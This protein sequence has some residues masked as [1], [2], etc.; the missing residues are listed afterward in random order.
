MTVWPV[1]VVVEDTAVGEEDHG[2]IPGPFNLV[3][4]SPMAR[5]RCDVSSELCC[6]RA[7]PE[8]GAGHSL[9][10]REYDEDSLLLPIKLQYF[11]YFSEATT[12][13]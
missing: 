7:S 3:T 5:H 1:G 10:Y 6:P 2:S 4:V 9:Q 12:I 11:I 8:D 13:Y